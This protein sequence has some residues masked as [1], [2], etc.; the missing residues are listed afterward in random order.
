MKRKLLILAML[1]LVFVFQTVNAQIAAKKGTTLDE[2]VKEVNMLLQKGDDDSKALAEKEARVM[3]SSKN[4]M[5]VLM[6]ASLY[7]YL[8]KK[9]EADKTKS[10]ITKKFPRGIQARKDA[11][12][13]FIDD[14]SLTAEQLERK[15][16]DWEKKFPKSYFEKLNTGEADY[17]FSIMTYYSQAAQRMARRL[18]KDGEYDK[19][20]TYLDKEAGV[21]GTLIAQDLF[22]SG[23]Y[24]R[25]LPIASSAY[26]KNATVLETTQKEENPTYTA[27]RNY[28][29]SAALY[30]KVLMKAGKNDESV[31]IAQQLFDSGHTLPSNTALLA[32]GL[33]KQGKDLDA[34]LVLH[35]A[36]VKSGRS[37]DNVVLYQAITPIY[38]KLNSGKG[39]FEQ[40]TS[41]LDSEISEA[42]TAKYK[43]QMIKKEAPLFSL[44]N[45]EGET[46][47]LVDLKGKVVVLDFWATWCGPCVTSFPGMQAAVNKFKEDKEVEFLFIDTWQREENYVEEVNKFIDDNKYTFHVLF[48]EMKDRDKATTTAY[49][50]KGIP[51]KVVIDKEG[52][53]R[54]ESSGSTADVDAIV[55]EM[56]TKIELVKNAG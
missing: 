26:K 40:Y 44:V 47:S 18:I 11:F 2:I 55:K 46:V 48:D 43:S 15:Y 7:N 4:E 25:A 37:S 35:N 50:V 27:K 17:G 21:D 12:E 30:A 45:R 13:A 16:A 23:Q 56:E 39:D 52:F 8:G 20:T 24:E 32:E 51:H 54:F 53:I 36:M 33:Q 22:E 28:N 5:F 19:I 31:K 9:E 42:L 10:S 29:S 41:S 3:A 49:G 38:G 34:F 14:E 6:A 1:G